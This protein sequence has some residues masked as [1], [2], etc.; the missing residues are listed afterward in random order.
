MKAKEIINWVVYFV[1]LLAVV[2]V[3]NTF[4]VQRTMVSGDSM[5][6]YLHNKDQLM[7]DK[8]SYRI[9][10]PERFDIVVF[11]V[12]RDGKEEYYIKRVIGLPGETVQIIDGY[13]YINGEKL[14]ENYGA[15]V[16][17]DAGRAAEPITLG[18]DEY[19]VLGDNR[20]RSDDSR[21]ENVEN[22]KREKIVGRA[23]VRIWPL[24][25]ICVVRHRCH[26]VWHFFKYERNDQSDFLDRICVH[27]Q[28]AKRI[29]NVRFTAEKHSPAKI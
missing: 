1:C 5:Y 24:D 14:D 11:P 13:V 18:D 4:V 17:N 26:F 6:P 25:R 7:M 12:V 28:V 27:E 20:N 29:V 3:I 19:F 22:L 8:L 21:Y 10:D 2:F 9:H 15:E 23:W 16:M